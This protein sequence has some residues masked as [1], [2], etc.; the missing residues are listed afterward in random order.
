VIEYRRDL[1]EDLP[2]ARELFREYASYIGIDLS[3]QGFEEELASLPGKYAPPGGTLI[4]ARTDGSPCGCVALRPIDPGTCEM[5]RLYV[6]PQARGHRIGAE[7]VRRVIEAAEAGGYQAMRLDTLQTMQ[8]AIA[9]YE[10]F[11]FRDIQPYIYN[12]LPG[13]R[14]MEKSLRP[15]S[16]QPPFP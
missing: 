16:A 2:V 12:P 1:A 9:L 6:R 7:L 10:S 11:G 13:A 15:R 3:F 14:F 8:G 5:K 4:L